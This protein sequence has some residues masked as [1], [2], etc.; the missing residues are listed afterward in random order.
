MEF[1]KGLRV[2]VVA[3]LVL[4]FGGAYGGPHAIAGSSSLVQ[5]NA[6]CTEL[7]MESATPGEAEISYDIDTKTTPSTGPEEDIE[8]T[9]AAQATGTPVEDVAS[10]LGDDRVLDADDEFFL[11]QD[12]DGDGTYELGVDVDQNGELDENEVLGTDE[13]ELFA[14]YEEASSVLGEDGVLDDSDD[15]YLHEDTN[16]DDTFEIGIDEDESGSL[17]EDEVLGVDLNND[18]ALT[19]DGLDPRMAEPGDD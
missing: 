4:L 6:D 8:A 1:A 19:K 15:G 11:C 12:V 16:D 9:P 2:S 13:N 5:E 7:V 17:E 18:E 10:L 3:L 14:N